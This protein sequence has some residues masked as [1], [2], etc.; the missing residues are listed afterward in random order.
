MSHENSNL[1][2]L[3]PTKKASANDI[4]EITKNS[5]T[6]TH[7]TLKPK[8]K[9][10]DFLNKKTDT[11]VFKGIYFEKELWTYIQNKAKKTGMN[12]SEII[13]KMIDFIKSQE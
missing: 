4:K 10:L 13:N 3:N 11:K 12:N 2:Q 6:I 7:D 1:F 8:V 9:S 5:I